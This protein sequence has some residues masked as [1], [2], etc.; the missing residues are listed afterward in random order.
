MPRA[1]GRSQRFL[2]PLYFC[3]KKNYRAPFFPNIEADSLFPYFTPHNK[4]NQET[5]SIP[6][7]LPFSSCYDENS[8]NS[9]I[10][11]VN[12]N[13]IV[14]YV[15][16]ISLEESHQKS[17]ESMYVHQKWKK[18]LNILGLTYSPIDWFEVFL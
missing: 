13:F 9:V 8:G 16:Q 17:P 12:W 10:V 3:K 1:E 11:F 15:L 14:S 5:S 18:V 6:K 7:I 4:H 2:I